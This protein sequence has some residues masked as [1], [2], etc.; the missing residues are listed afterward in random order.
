MLRSIRFCFRSISITSLLMLLSSAGLAGPNPGKSTTGTIEPST[1]THGVEPTSTG[2]ADSTTHIVEPTSSSHTSTAAPTSSSH[3]STAT[4]IPTGTPSPKPLATCEEYPATSRKKAICSL[5]DKFTPIRKGQWTPVITLQEDTLYIVD[6]ESISVNAP[7]NIPKGSALLPSPNNP[8]LLEITF[9]PVTGSSDQ[10]EFCVLVYG[11]GAR[12]AGVRLDVSKGGPET[13]FR[14]GLLRSAPGK[15]KSIIYGETS[16]SELSESVLIGD[17]ECDSLI[18]QKHT[19]LQAVQFY[20]G[21]L[22]YANGSRNIIKV[23]NSSDKPV[24]V[25]DKVIWQLEVRDSIH[26]LDG[27]IASGPMQAG[28]AVTNLIPLISGNTVVYTP[29]SE[30]ESFTRSGFY[31]LDVPRVNIS[32]NFHA[33]SEIEYRRKEDAAEEFA[34]NHLTKTKAVS[35][36]NSYIEGMT[37]VKGEDTKLDYGFA[38]NKYYSDLNITLDEEAILRYPPG[39][40]LFEGSALRLNGTLEEYE[41]SCK[42]QS[43]VSL[44]DMTGPEPGN[45]KSVKLEDIL[46]SCNSDCGWWSRSWEWGL[47]AAVATGVIVGWLTSKPVLF[48][49]KKV[50]NFFPWMFKKLGRGNTGGVNLSGSRESLLNSNK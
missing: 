2:A 10:C 33:V 35:F 28:F 45:G 11:E 44:G 7:F 30:P 46:A 19:G 32:G 39:G 16:A 47:P 37:S 15:I 21:N 43:I 29:L 49:I 26:I 36:S 42:V 8:N 3:T 18:Q 20:S 24:S 4:P 41:Q 34:W 25:P 22:L 6:D 48:M 14:N 38:N 31:M 40:W 9:D 1:T 13:F 12:V 5:Y 27:S 50:I 23:E 17:D